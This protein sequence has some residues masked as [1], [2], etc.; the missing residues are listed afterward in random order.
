MQL[1]DL[2]LLKAS[3]NVALDDALLA[4]A[5]EG[6]VSETLRLWDAPSTFIVL[7]RG[8][9][10]ADE[11]AVEL[12]D[13]DSIP[14]IRRISGGATIL[15]A[16]GCMFYSV[17]LSLELR[18]HLR[19][20]DEAHDFVMSR[21]RAALKNLKPNLE[22][23]GTCDLVTDN[24]KT[25]GNALRVGRDW[26]LY[27][28]T[29]LLNMDLSLVDQYLKHPPR[30]PEYRGGRSHVDF[31]ANLGVEREAAAAELIKQWN[32]T[33]SLNAEQIE[34]LRVAAE[35]LDREKYTRSSWNR[36]R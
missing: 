11:V 33:T 21:I 26:L 15:A 16:P 22:L 36:S 9:R 29:L 34:S 10:Y 17:L 25:S 24:R 14:I 8:S 12:A 4:Q 6:Q 19:M 5:E 28:G 20:L 1:L 32:A 18:P 27:H 7:G 30:E 23:D 35:K 13:R 2:T 3:A 31:I